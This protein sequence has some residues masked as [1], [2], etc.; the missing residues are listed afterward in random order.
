MY[1]IEDNI[2][3][4]KLGTEEFLCYEIPTPRPILMIDSFKQNH[5]KAKKK[6]WKQK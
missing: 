1:P 3:K 6:N 2:K 5:L 4:K